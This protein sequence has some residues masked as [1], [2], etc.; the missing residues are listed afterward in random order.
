MFNEEM[1]T[2]EE[3]MNIIYEVSREVHQ[4]D[5]VARTY[6]TDDLL[7][8]TEVH[9]ISLIGRAP[10][11]TITEI[12]LKTNKTKSAV[13]QIVDKLKTKGMLEKVK[14]SEDNRRFILILTEKGE[15]IY[16]YHE[17]LDRHSYQSLFEG[18]KNIDLSDMKIALKVLLEMRKQYHRL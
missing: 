10:R 3:F 17:D 6:G 9:T 14:D 8:M 13:S 2:F 4:Y 18:M 5:T 7:Y 12:A 1:K 11:I 16:R 15:I